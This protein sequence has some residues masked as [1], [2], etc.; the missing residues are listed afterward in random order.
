MTCK[1]C[2]SIATTYIDPLECGFCELCLA[3]ID[4]RIRVINL[5]KDYNELIYAVASKYPNETRHQTALRYIKEMEKSEL[6]KKLF[7]D[8][9]PLTAASGPHIQK[10]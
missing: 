5:Q 4:E 8:T 10:L 3:R 7:T 2:N 9:S 1:T 6:V